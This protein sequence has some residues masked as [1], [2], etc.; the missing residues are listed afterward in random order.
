MSSCSVLLLIPMHH[1]MTTYGGMDVKFLA[2]LICG[3]DSRSGRFSTGK[4][5]LGIL[6][7]L[8]FGLD[9]ESI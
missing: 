3:K 9:P 1:A 8:K 7:G 2:V 5:P 6:V 4:I